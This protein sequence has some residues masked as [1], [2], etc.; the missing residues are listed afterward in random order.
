[1]KKYEGKNNVLFF[2]NLVHDYYYHIEPNI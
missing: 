1:M 2:W